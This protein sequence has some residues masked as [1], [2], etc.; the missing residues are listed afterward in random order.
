MDG[1][2]IQQA[3]E[4]AIRSGATPISVLDEL[5]HIDVGVPIAVMTYYNIAFRMGLERFAHIL[6]DSGVSAAILP[7][8]PIDEAAPWTVAADDAGVE[9]ILLAAPTA[10][11][12]RL[13]RIA[14]RC[15]GFVYGVGLVGITGVRDELADSATAIAQRLKNITEKP[16]LIGVGIGTPQQAAEVC[17]VADGV[18]IGSAVVRQMLTGEGPDAVGELVE[19]FRA[20][21]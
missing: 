17:Q 18:V 20:V 5:R 19:Q 21:L 14:E 16:V 13:A 12:E 15:R 6:I 4:L 10:S 2:V 11:D 3:S 1:P 9:T 8:L 7:D